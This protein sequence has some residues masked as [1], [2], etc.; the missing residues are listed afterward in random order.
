MDQ[1]DW[2]YQPVKNSRSKLMCACQH[3]DTETAL[4]L[5][6]EGADVNFVDDA[7]RTALHVCV[8]N[9]PNE[10]IDYESKYQQNRI[11][12]RLI[13]KGAKLDVQD[14]HGITP[15]MMAVMSNQ[16]R[17]DAVKMLVDAGAKV[18]PVEKHFQNNA[19]HW[20][21]DLGNEGITEILC[22]AAPQLLDTQNINGDTP[23]DIATKKTRDPKS[24]KN[25]LSMLEPAES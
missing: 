6:D 2:E 7:Q 9:A 8:C 24:S 23:F 3:G 18:D 5:I 12:R 16:I 25:L 4:S 1:K 17:F 10:L 13:D 14:S 22:K 19:L 21:A 20:A 15:L 11:T